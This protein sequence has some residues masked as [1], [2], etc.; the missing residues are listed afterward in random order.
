MKRMALDRIGQGAAFGKGKD[1][2]QRH[3][4][5]R[6]AHLQ[7]G[8]AEMG[9][10]R[11]R[12]ERQ[13]IWVDRGFVLV[14]I[15]PRAGDLARLQ[16]LGQGGLI[17]HIAAR[18]VDEEAM[19]LHAGQRLG[20]DEVAGGRPAGDG[21]H[22]DAAAPVA[23]VIQDGVNGKLVDFFD[24]AGWSAAL[25]DALARPEALAAVQEAICRKIG[26]DPGA[27]DERAFLEAFYAQLRERLEADMRFG[28]RKADKFS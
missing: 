4:T 17:H 28:K 7:R 6:G 5:H 11:D 19:R 3:K 14:D 10:E 13:K 12:V 9:Q 1:I 21:D 2:V 27:G 23:E 15:Q 26:W 20:V 24:V 25:S 16:R 18:D 8:G 22:H